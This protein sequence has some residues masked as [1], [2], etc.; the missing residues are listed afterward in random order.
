MTNEQKIDAL[1]EL[2]NDVMHTLNMKQ[3]C[4]DDAT[5]SHQC[6][7]EADNYHQQMLNILHSQENN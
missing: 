5:E 4:I 7:V 3:Y 6:E 2:L 1:T